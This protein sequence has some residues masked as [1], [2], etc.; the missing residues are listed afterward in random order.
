MTAEEG[1]RFLGWRDVPVDR[2]ATAS[3]R[4]RL[5]PAPPSGLRSAPT[6]PDD[7]AALERK[8]LRDPQAGRDGAPRQESSV[9]ELF[10]VASLSCRTSDL[11]GTAAAG[12]DSGLLPGPARPGSDRARWRWCT[13][14]SAPTRCRRGTAP[15]RSATWRT[16]AR[17]TRCAATSTGCMPARR[18]S[19]RRSF[20][21][22]MAKILPGDRAERQRLG[23]ASTTP[24]SCSSTPAAR[25]R[26]PS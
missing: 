4:A 9:S 15:I 2:T 5:A 25:C 7:R 3:W 11:Q 1:Q 10:Y 14:A 18:A 21:D 22:D 23:D 6:A 20:G 17:S 24:W 16:T 26:T 8:L 13:S 12:A 19:R